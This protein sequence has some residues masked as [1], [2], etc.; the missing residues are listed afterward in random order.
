MYLLLGFVFILVIVLIVYFAAK[1]GDEL[2]VP[3][4]IPNVVAPEEKPP[5]V[6]PIDDTVSGSWYHNAKCT[7]EALD[8]FNE[9]NIKDKQACE[10]SCRLASKSLKRGIY[11]YK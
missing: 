5:I 2:V 9:D 1:G 8:S 6:L 11:N 7:G 10:N 4:V 3:T